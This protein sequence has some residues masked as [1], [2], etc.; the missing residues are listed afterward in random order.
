ML[1]WV[2][3]VF[4]LAAA[5]YAQDVSRMDQAV[6]SFVANKQF[7]GSVLVA[8]GDQVLFSKGYG[9]ANLEWSIPNTPDTKF[10]IGS[11]TKQF[12]AAAILRLEEQGKLKIGDPVRKYLPDEPAAWDKVAIRH[13]LTHT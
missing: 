10:R 4:L 13:L 1:R 2:L 9:Y 12:T 11:M 6:Q 8:R 3:V 7:M 5:G